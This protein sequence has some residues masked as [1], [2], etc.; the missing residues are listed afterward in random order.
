MARQGNFM[1]RERTLIEIVLYAIYLYLSALS[2]RQIA[3]ALKSIGMKRS[4]EAI[5]K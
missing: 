1:K 4:H 2:L 5:R 3:R